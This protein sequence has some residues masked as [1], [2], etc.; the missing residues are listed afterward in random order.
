MNRMNDPQSVCYYHQNRNVA[1]T[2]NILTGQKIHL[3]LQYLNIQI[4][5]YS[6]SE[7]KSST[8]HT[9]EQVCFK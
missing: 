8:V 3:R 4:I 2:M 5:Q 7:S 6:L 9:N 1:Y